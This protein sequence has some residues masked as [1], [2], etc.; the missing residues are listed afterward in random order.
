MFKNTECLHF[1]FWKVT[2]CATGKMLNILSVT[3]K[4]WNIFSVAQTFFQWPRHFFSGPVQA[5]GQCQC[6]QLRAAVPQLRAAA[7]QLWPSCAAAVP[8]LDP[9]C[10]PNCAPLSGAAAFTT[11]SSLGF[12][13]ICKGFL[14]IHRIN[15]GH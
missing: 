3:E 14:A 11:S 8:Q 4:C 13:L 12:P 10:A 9:S 1:Y 7:P 6:T 15:N 5:F 2:G